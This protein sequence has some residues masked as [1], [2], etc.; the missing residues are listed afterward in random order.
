VKPAVFKLAACNDVISPGL[1]KQFSKHQCTVLPIDGNKKEG[2]NTAHCKPEFSASASFAKHHPRKVKT[3]HDLVVLVTC[4][5]PRANCSS[6]PFSD[7]YC[8]EFN[9]Q[10]GK[11][12]S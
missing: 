7:L 2:H 12:I 10:F 4:K 9:S 3:E 1:A 8:V 5:V 6:S 11:K